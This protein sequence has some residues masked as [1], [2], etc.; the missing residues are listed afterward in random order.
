MLQVRASVRERL[1]R[2]FEFHVEGPEVLEALR[3]T[4]GVRREQRQKV[5]SRDVQEQR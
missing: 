5:L 2:I 4:E 3:P 1:C